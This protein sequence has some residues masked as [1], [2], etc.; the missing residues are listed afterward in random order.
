MKKKSLF[1]AAALSA[2]MMLSSCK[3]DKDE[4]PETLY[5]RLGGVNAISAVVDKFI[6]Y[7]AADP[8]MV[9]TFTP[10]LND[11]QAGNTARLTSLRNNLIDQIGEASGG[12]QMYKGKD[13]VTAHKGMN[14]TETEFNSLVGNLVK[15]LNDFSVPST[16][17]NEL[18]GVLGGLKGQI[19]G[20]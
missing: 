11:V 1:L 14:I 9:R 8:N 10:L 4:A 12:P 13:M 16:E 3:K 2:A 20:K 18:L 6:G 17:Q 5:V 15:A 7:V 19:V